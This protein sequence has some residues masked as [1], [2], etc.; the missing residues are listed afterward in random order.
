ME[1]KKEEVEFI[2]DNTQMSVAEVARHLN[3][4]V[5]SVHSKLNRMGVHKPRS[6]EDYI[7]LINDVLGISLT[8]EDYKLAT[9]VSVRS[10]AEGVQNV[11]RK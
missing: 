7:D 2:R 9:R 3:R 5:F 11:L 6:K 1:W 4:S 8:V 10:L